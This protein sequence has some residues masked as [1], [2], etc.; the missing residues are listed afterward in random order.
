MQGQAKHVR[1]SGWLELEQRRIR[2]RVQS[3]CDYSVTS[4]AKIWSRNTAQL[5]SDG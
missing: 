2:R 5:A 1:I 3:I 4:C